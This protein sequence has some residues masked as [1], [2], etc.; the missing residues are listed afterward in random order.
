M[1]VWWAWKRTLLWRIVGALE[2][3][4]EEMSVTSRGAFLPWILAC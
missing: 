4:G 2:A 1:Y 3:C